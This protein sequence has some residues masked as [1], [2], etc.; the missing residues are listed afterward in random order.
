MRRIFKLPSYFP[1][2]FVSYLSKLSKLSST[3]EYMLIPLNFAL[4]VAWSY[5]SDTFFKLPEI[6]WLMDQRPH[7]KEPISNETM[8]SETVQVWRAETNQTCC[9]ILASFEFSILTH[10]T[11]IG[12]LILKIY[13]K[14]IQ[15]HIDGRKHCYSLWTIEIFK[16]S[17][18]INPWINLGFEESLCH[19]VNNFHV[20]SYR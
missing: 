11:S 19:F 15:C 1:I 6:Y 13:E 16:V 7:R 3:A 14:I 9:L 12:V 17:D 5:S 20:P 10:D 18:L 2:V 8:I 4:R